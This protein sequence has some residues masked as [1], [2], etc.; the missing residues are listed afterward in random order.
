MTTLGQD[1]RYALRVLRQ[2]PGF[3]AIAIGTL[4]LGIGANAAIFSV[5]DAV[6]LKP[7]PFARSGELVRVTSDFTRRGAT[8][9]GLSAPELFDYRER[10]GV[11]QSMS[12][13]YPITANVTGGDRPERVETLLVDVE[14][15]DI[16][17]VKAQ[18]GRLFERKDYDPGIADFVVLSDGF[19]RRRFGADPAVIGKPLR[20]DDD[21]CTILGVLPPGFRHPGRVIET[22]V[23]VWAPSGWLGPP[24]QGPNRKAYFLQGALARLKPGVTP[25]VAQARLDA[26]A[27]DLRR[28]Y[29]RD[30]PDNDG[31]APRL[32]P[33]Q[34]DLVGGVRPALVIL[35]AAVG[36]VL[37]IAC[38][39]VANL[40]L[41]RAS[42]RRREIAVRQALGASRTRLL[43]QLLTESLVVAAAGGV[44]GLALAAFGV[45]L[46]TRLS[47]PSIL[48]LQEVRIDR[49]VLLFT[50]GAS[51]LTGLLFGIVPAL[52]GSAS[53][54]GAALNESSRGASSRGGKRIRSVLVVAEFALALVLL[55]GAG[56]LVR[57]LV[58]LQ[59]V[60]VGFEPANVTTASLWLPQPDIRENGRYNKNSEQAAFYRKALER[61]RALPGVAE[62]AGATR[63]PFNSGRFTSRLEI[64]GRDPER[65]GTAVAE[66]SGASS[67]YFATLD[68]PLKAGRDFDD[69]DTEDG[70]RVLIVSE[71]FARR[72]FPGEDP[73]GKRLRFPGLPQ[74]RQVVNGG[75]PPPW[76]SIVGVVGDVKTESLALEDRPT[77]YRPL[78][79]AASPIFTFVVKGDAP[80]ATL[81]PQLDA[82]IRGLDPELP[83]FAVRTMDEAMAATI[84][85][86][87][88]AMQLLALFAAA[89]LVLSA[90]GIY[91]VIAYG[92][93]QRTREIGI[94]MALGARP[95]DVRRMLLLEGGRLAA[96]GVAVGL[97]GSIL[98]THAMS[99]LLYGV[100]PRDPMT[101]AS[102]PAVLAAVALAATFFPAR[103]ASR[104]DPTTA[105]RSE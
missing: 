52:Q 97:F 64:E 26:V 79:Q 1:L 99:A 33:L 8:D 60:P 34:D 44:I 90:V 92:V 35:L 57:T 77:F 104:V 89:A 40:Q 50:L 94:R 83:V 58:R 93:A 48:R 15:F 23:E 91:G 101:L 80:P 82:A 73:L 102:V 68:I 81:G 78:L 84:A 38:A 17:G 10:A 41:A 59:Q 76:M 29:A 46:L 69:R 74:Q 18:V 70:A 7:L 63:V 55:V 12:G 28:E 71:S 54:L 9:V 3:A 88:F 75:A 2:S 100:G 65:D 51:I 72:F 36:L 16:L 105:L 21:L 5:V 30:Y 56:L 87:R 39:N 4:A 61:I 31:W 32:I 20:I 42:A 98:L 37:L 86:R 85:E 11:F 62:A 53:A 45:D 49:I 6:L 96:A 14:Y 19:W 66:G 67:R 95:A 103:R 43:R 22:D 27:S 47:P 25:A 13:L 24:F